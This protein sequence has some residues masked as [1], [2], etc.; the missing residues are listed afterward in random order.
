MK[1]GGKRDS[2]IPIPDKTVKS[3]HS[4]NCCA[5][6]VTRKIIPKPLSRYLFSLG[7]MVQNGKFSAAAMLVLVRTLKKVDLPTLG[8]PTIPHL[9]FVPMRPIS[10]CFSS[11]TFFFLGGILDCWL[12]LANYNKGN[13]AMLFG[14]LSTFSLF[15]FL[16]LAWEER[17]FSGSR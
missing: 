10:T 12:Q 16:L 9:R 2:R 1:L 7:S 5:P 3:L 15:A 6:S 14:F 4:D 11:S 8:R 17:L 13:E